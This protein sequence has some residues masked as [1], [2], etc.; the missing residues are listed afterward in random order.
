MCLWLETLAKALTLS[1]GPCLVGFMDNQ[2]KIVRM[3]DAP[4]CMPITDRY[5]VSL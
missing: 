3:L 5:R 4:L 1:S 2:P